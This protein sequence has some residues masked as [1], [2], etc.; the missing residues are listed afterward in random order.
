MCQYS[1]KKLA[2][3]ASC[4]QC[5]L[6]HYNETVERMC[7][8]TRRDSCAAER[9]LA[10]DFLAGKVFVLEVALADVLLSCNHHRSHAHPELFQ[11][12]LCSHHLCTSRTYI[13]GASL[14]NKD[15]TMA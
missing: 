3:A 9:D 11:H 8:V 6:L 10:A 13:T 7:H 4:E 14:N 15:Y 12:V 1:R 5:V 2:F